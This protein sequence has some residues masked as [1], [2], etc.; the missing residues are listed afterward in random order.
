MVAGV[1]RIRFV[2]HVSG[3]SDT[4]DRRTTT[5]NS[6]ECIDLLPAL[7]PSK[8]GKFGVGWGRELGGKLGWWDVAD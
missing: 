3:R 1:G 2:D 7:G 6:I 8:S 4:P 5:R